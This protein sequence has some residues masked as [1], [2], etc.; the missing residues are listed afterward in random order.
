MPQ[1]A[2]VPSAKPRISSGKENAQ[3]QA[4]IDEKNERKSKR[5]DKVTNKINECFHTFSLIFLIPKP[6]QKRKG[7]KPNLNET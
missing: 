3:N 7:I 5:K 1:K 2:P 4:G 6:Y